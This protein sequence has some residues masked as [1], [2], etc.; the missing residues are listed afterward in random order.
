[1]DSSSNVPL[2]RAL[3]SIAERG[4]GHMSSNNGDVL[5]E[6]AVAGAGIAVQP[7]FITGPAV[8]SGQLQVILEE[9]APEPLGLYAIYAHRQLLASKVRAFIDFMEGYFGDPPYWDRFDLPRSGATT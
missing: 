2:F 5:L 9:Y 3:Q 1:M 7:T 6:A 4:E 8:A